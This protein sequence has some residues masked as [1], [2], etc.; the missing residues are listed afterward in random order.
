MSKG[1]LE[2]KMFKTKLLISIHSPENTKLN[3][4]KTYSFLIFLQN[5]SNIGPLLT[6]P[7]QPSY[8]SHHYLLQ[9]SLQQPPKGGGFELA[10][11]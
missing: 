9:E 2:L 3:K 10:L 5:I 6:P 11:Q 7:L 4:Q 8:L 1:Y